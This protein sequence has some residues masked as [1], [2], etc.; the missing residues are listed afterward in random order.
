MR[1]G[2]DGHSAVRSVRF[3][4]SVADQRGQLPQG[5]PSWRK[6]SI[7]EEDEDVSRTWRAVPGPERTL[8]RS[9]DCLLPRGGSARTIPRSTPPSCGRTRDLLLGGSITWGTRVSSTPRSNAWHTCLRLCKSLLR[10]T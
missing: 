2:G 3:V 10:D 8:C 5:K 9:S 6:L 1:A 4:P 7:S